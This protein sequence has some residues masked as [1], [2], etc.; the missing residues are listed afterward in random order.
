MTGKADFQPDEWD[1]VLEGPTF[2]GTLAATAQGGGTFRESFALA[3][4][5]AE[6]RK[7]HGESQLLDEIAATKPKLERYHSTEE[8]HEKGLPRLKQAVELVEQKGTPEEVEAYRR[9][10]LAVAERV[11]EAHKEN[12]QQ[13]SPNEQAAIDEIAA[14]IGASG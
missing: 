11:A 14:T 8:M 4:A 6:A 7:Q 3:K 2:A 12:G 1:L 10:V 13:V 9:F 5:Y